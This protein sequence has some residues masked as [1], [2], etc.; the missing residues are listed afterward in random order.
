MWNE[1]IFVMYKMLTLWS[2]LSTDTITPI[3]MLVFIVWW[4]K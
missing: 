2:V 4:K 1:W 3:Y